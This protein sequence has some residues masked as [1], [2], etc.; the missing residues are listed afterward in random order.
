MISSQDIYD[1]VKSWPV[2]EQVKF[3]ALILNDV[4]HSDALTTVE[5]STD[6]ITGEEI[7]AALERVYARYSDTLKR[8]AE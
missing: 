7:Q 2:A 4:S 8:L 3:V 5:T 1:T 6:N